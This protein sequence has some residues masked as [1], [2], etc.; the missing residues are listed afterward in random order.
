[1]Q[2]TDMNFDVLGVGCW[3]PFVILSHDLSLNYYSWKLN[4]EIIL[5]IM[6]M[7]TVPY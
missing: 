5:T 1:M 7:E 6:I 2:Y 3:P 4:Y